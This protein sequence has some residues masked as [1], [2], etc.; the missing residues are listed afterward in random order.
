MIKAAILDDYQNIALQ[1]ADWSSLDGQ[2]EITAFNDHLFD[3]AAIAER[4]AD[5]EILILNRER[6]PFPKSLLDRLPKLKLLVTSGMHNRAIDFGVTKERGI[7]VC[8]SA[9][10]SGS[11]PELTW[12]LILA[13]ARNIIGEDRNVREGRW[14][15]TVGLGLEGKVLGVIGLG[16]LGKPVARVGKEFGMEIIT[17]SPNMSQSRADEVGAVAV[18]KDGLLATSDFVTL[19]VPLN[20]GSRGLLQAED[21]AKMKK[22][23]FLINTSRGPL[24][25]EQAL[26]EAVRGGVIAGAGLDVYDV[27]P[28]PQDHPIRSLENTVL[29][30]HLGYVSDLTYRASFHDAVGDIEAWLNGKPVRVIN[31]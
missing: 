18:S 12:G 20:G 4:L 6:T 9:M 13:L 30:P 28:L 1:Y 26:I 25:D 21:L 3:E 14:Q 24:V 16:R 2:V 10:K 23:A 7:L 31:P 19:H 29:T 22:T 8:G 11:T 15:Q 27:E 17:W 5:F